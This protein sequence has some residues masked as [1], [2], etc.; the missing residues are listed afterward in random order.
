VCRYGD[1]DVTSRAIEN[2]SFHKI[3]V[4]HANRFTHRMTLFR[5][6]YN[7]SHCA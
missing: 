2:I 5:Y 7:R 4:V 6:R 1:L 3:I